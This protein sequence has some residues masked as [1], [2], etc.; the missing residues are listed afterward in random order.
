[1]CNSGTI[2]NEADFRI[3]DKRDKSLFKKKVVFIANTSVA[4]AKMAIF[5]SGIIAINVF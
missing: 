2:K 5:L 4:I 3:S 1:M